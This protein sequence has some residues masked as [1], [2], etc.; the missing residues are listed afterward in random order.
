ML[1][2]LRILGISACVFLPLAHSIDPTSSTHLSEVVAS[3][4]LLYRGLAH[5]YNSQG[6]RNAYPDHLELNSEDAERAWNLA[7]QPGHGPLNTFGS[8][9]TK[10]RA[11]ALTRIPFGH[12]VIAPYRIGEKQAYLFWEVEHNS[13]KLL[14]MEL[15][16]PGGI[17]PAGHVSFS[18]LMAS[19]PKR[20]AVNKFM[21]S[22]R[23]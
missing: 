8:R 16:P 14:G 5:R 9:E 4:K 22:F 13:H 20:N 19:L 12:E 7:Q 2:L 21:K 23:G 11:W 6:Y 1:S 10:A 3:R 15:W 18:E 17:F